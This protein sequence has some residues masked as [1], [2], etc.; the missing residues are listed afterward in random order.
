MTFPHG[1]K[2]G[3]TR[4]NEQSVGGAVGYEKNGGKNCKK[5]QKNISKTL[6]KPKLL[7]YNIQAFSEELT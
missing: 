2:R 5:S 6:D 7:C 3:K 1:A 4:A